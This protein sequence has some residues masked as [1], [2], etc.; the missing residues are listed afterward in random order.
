MANIGSL[1]VDLQANSAAFITEMNKARV[2]AERTANGM[3]TAMTG[4][5]RA[6]QSARQFVV[7]FL[8][9][10]SAQA[11]V[12]FA[13]HVVETAGGMGEL[14]EQLGIST[15]ALQAYT[16]AASQS[17]LSAEQMQAAFIRLND[18]IGNATRGTKEAVDS[19]ARLGV[20]ILDAGGQVRSTEAVLDDIAEGLSKI[21]DPARRAAAA[22]DLFGRAGARLLP[23]LSGGAAGLTRFREEARQAGAII[24]PAM[25]A[26]ADA[27]A[28]AWAALKLEIAAIATGPAVAFF[29]LLRDTLQLMRQA[30][31]VP[32]DLGQRAGA[33]LRRSTM[34]AEEIQA[35][36]DEERIR[37]ENANWRDPDWL[38]R[39]P[40]GPGARNPAVVS[41]GDAQKDANAIRD[42]QDQLQRVNQEFLGYNRSAAIGEALS[43]LSASATARQREQMQGLAED[44]FDTTEARRRLDDEERDGQQIW[45]QTRTASENLRDRLADLNYLYQQGAITADEYGR[46][47]RDAY[48]KGTELG[49]AVDTLGDSFSSAFEA[50]IV[51]GESLRNVLGNLLADVGRLLVRMAVLEPL[52]QAISQGIGSLFGGGG[53]ASSG[54]GGYS[55]SAWGNVLSPRGPI[56]LA[57]GGVVSG[58][59]V[60]LIG[61]GMYNEAVVPLPDGRRIPVDMRGGGRGGTTQVIN[62]DARGADPGVEI[63]L[64]ALIERSSETTLARAAQLNRD[65]GAYARQNGARRR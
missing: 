33:A 11:L 3:Q 45:E 52:K 48:L 13:Q 49:Q 4:V 38:G 9:T 34:S 40:R 57:G 24:D 10:L 22:N 55:A 23:L 32:F 25:I 39:D 18:T 28:D 19:F 30:A 16:Y 58:P 42:M 6:F 8:G 61:E 2:A 17:G 43:R 14:A 65:G 31:S 51:K 36:D 21:E 64:R 26:R 59:H 37:R 46:A 12:S 53:G 41:R 27:L 5:G 7:G 47:T 62:I 35:L 29:E 1:V 60:A 15:D 44:I 20:R 54:G 56:A 50:A 63:R